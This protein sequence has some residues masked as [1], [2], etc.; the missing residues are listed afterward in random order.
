ML[1]M[2]QPLAQNSSLVQSPLSTQGLD[3]SGHIGMSH[4]S[5]RSSGSPPGQTMQRSSPHGCVHRSTL[6]QAGQEAGSCR[7][8]SSQSGAV[9]GLIATSTQ[10]AS[11]HS[12]Q[13]PKQS[14]PGG[15]SLPQFAM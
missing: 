6:V 12:V 7:V 2:Q 8:V 13:Q 5:G 10:P 4:E 11:S 9:V 3:P 14:Q 15:T 1:T